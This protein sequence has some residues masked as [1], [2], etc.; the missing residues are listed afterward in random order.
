[1]KLWTGSQSFKLPKEQHKYMRIAIDIDSTLHHYWDILSEVSVRRFGIELPYDEQF[2]WG[3][4]RLRPEQLALCIDESHSDERILAGT[5]YPGAVQAVRRWHEEGHFVHI[6]SH[7]AADRKRPTAAW[8][9]QIG[10]PFDDLHCS[11]DKVSRCVELEIGLLIDDGPLNLDAALQRGI[12]VATIRHPWNR[13]LCDEEDVICAGDW[14]ELERKLTP[15]LARQGT[16][17]GA[18]N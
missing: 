7:R 16:G 5:P 12:A 1:M 17:V 4:T 15:V 11:Y 8:L 9:E 3:I 2:T 18:A 14:P 13:D 10:L 6:T